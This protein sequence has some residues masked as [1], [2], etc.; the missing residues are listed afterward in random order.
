MSI[1]VAVIGAGW[2]GCTTCEELISKGIEFKLYD[3]NGIFTGSSSHNQN[4]IHLG[5]HYPRSKKTRDIC[6][7]SYHELVS[8]YKE[9]VSN[10][11]KN[12]YFIADNSLV[13]AETYLDIFRNHE[14]LFHIEEPCI[15]IEKTTLCINTKEFYIDHNIVRDK[16][17]EQLSSY[18]IKER[19]EEIEEREDGCY[20]NKIRYDLIIDCSNNELGLMK[21]VKDEWTMSLIYKSK[22]DKVI[23]VTIMDGSFFSIYPYIVEDKLYTLTSVSHITIPSREVD[24]KLLREKREVIE[25]EVR[26]HCKEYFEQNFEYHGYFISKKTKPITGSDCRDLIIQRQGNII[27]VACC[28]IGGI[29]KYRNYIRNILSHHHLQQQ[30]SLDPLCK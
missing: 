19:V 27:S 23:G 7:E 4:R 25:K 2:Y 21:D 10:L 18:L 13:D 14:D 22:M 12:Y 9:A 16:W 8:K 26:V 28:K 29:V 24:E 6:L 17:E 30:V 11:Y 20:V 1:K 3:Q 15:P 5:F